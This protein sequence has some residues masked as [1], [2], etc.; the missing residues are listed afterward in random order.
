MEEAVL[1]RSNSEVS[2]SDLLWSLG[3]TALSV[4][5]PGMSERDADEY[6]LPGGSPALGP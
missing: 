5:L 4:T 6:A 2:R 3:N 1:A